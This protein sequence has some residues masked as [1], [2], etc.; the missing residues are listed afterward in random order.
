MGFYVTLPSDSSSNYFPE[1][2]ISHYVTRLPSTL[3]LTGSWEVGVVEFIYP[4]MWNNVNS[5]EPFKYDLGNDKLESRRISNGYYE[6]PV[7]IIKA[8]GSDLHKEKDIVLNY[9]KH[10]K[11][12]KL[13][14]KRGTRLIL[15]TGIAESLGFDPGEVTP[16][17]PCTTWQSPDYEKQWDGL[18]LSS[19][20]GEC[21][22][23]S[24][25]EIERN[26]LK[27]VLGPATNTIESPSSADP[28]ADFRLFYIYCDIVEPQIVG[29]V[30]APLLRIVTVKGQDGEMVHELYDR[31]HYIPL[32]RKK[33]QSIE[34]VIRTHLGR[35]VSFDRGRLIVKLH[36]REKHL[37]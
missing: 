14:S 4:H 20:N 28:N 10:T 11:K 15:P 23:L 1:N 2:K 25:K 24:A 29:D 35:L 8:M 19:S 17:R 18:E 5:V 22:K 7:E 32:I 9:N 34:I 3:D 26:N 6:S 36:F 31:P 21:L 27:P 37:V 16:P 12:V 30:Y 13:I 33:F